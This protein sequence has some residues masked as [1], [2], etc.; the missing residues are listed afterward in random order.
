MNLMSPHPHAV[1]MLPNPAPSPLWITCIHVADV[2][3]LR[4]THALTSVAV[5]I[6]EYLERT[7]HP[8]I[9][10]DQMTELVNLKHAC[11]F[12]NPPSPK[13]PLYEASYYYNSC[14]RPLLPL[15]IVHVVVLIYKSSF[16]NAMQ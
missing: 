7:L 15:C 12:A 13:T 9:T 11:R 16:T 5:L 10:W 3:L 6:K 4:F 8:P 1:F 2:N 14:V